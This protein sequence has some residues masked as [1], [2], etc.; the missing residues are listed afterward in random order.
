MQGTSTAG[1]R[2]IC[3]REYYQS[4]AMPISIRTRLGESWLQIVAGTAGQTARIRLPGSDC[5]DQTG[6]LFLP[7]LL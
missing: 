2:I 3:H 6:S 7:G 4:Q 5:P 1:R